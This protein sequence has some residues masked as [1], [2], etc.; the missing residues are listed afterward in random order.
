MHERLTDDEQDEVGREM[1][2]A[3]IK[4][5][6]DPIPDSEDSQDQIAR[7]V[8]DAL[9]AAAG[10]EKS[11]EKRLS[12]LKG[13]NAYVTTEPASVVATAFWIWSEQL[14]FEADDPEVHPQSVAGSKLIAFAR[15]LAAASLADEALAMLGPMGEI[16][17]GSRGARL[18]LKHQEPACPA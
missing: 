5:M 4:A 11:E 6:G 15:G 3:A 8:V 13:W 16:A 9:A 12:E 18:L 10:V 14:P 17:F 2:A 1:L 7:R